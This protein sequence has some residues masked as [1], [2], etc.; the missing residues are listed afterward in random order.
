MLG[1]L[2]ATLVAL[3]ALT[4]LQE[5]ARPD[6]LADAEQWTT[7]TATGPT[8]APVTVSGT[9]GA[10][11]RAGARETQPTAPLVA[12]SSVEHPTSTAAPATVPPSVPPTTVTTSEPPVT[13]T[14]LPTTSSSET[15]TTTLETT[16]T[17]EDT[18]TTTRATTTVTEP[19]PEPTTTVPTTTTVEPTTTEDPSDA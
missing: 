11:G 16:T 18:T 13:S 10:F 2:A 14:S 9:M 7:S 6:P 1:I 17:S 4:S 15:T 12:I 5:A 3:A 19:P 8:S